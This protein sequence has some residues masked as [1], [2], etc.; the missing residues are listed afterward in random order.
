[1]SIQKINYKQWKR[2]DKS[3]D[4]KEAI[5][6]CKKQKFLGNPSPKI[7]CQETK[8]QENPDVQLV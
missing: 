7:T 1:M 6:Q 2:D 5:K 4:E 8:C 3:H